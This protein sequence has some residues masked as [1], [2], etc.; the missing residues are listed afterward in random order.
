MLPA[1][2]PVYGQVRA[3]LAVRACVLYRDVKP[4]NVLLARPGRVL[5]TDFGIATWKAR[6]H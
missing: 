2:H 5:L 6:R 4:A 3:V 1:G